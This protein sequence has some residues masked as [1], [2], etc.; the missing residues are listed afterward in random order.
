MTLL[1]K[2]WRTLSLHSRGKFTSKKIISR[3]T[4]F[5]LLIAVNYFQSVAPSIRVNW[6]FNYIHLDQYSTMQTMDGSTRLLTAECISMVYRFL[7]Y[8]MLTIENI[9]VYKV[10]NCF[11]CLIKKDFKREK[12]FTYMLSIHFYVK[13]DI[14]KNE[15]F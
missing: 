14:T 12:D 2:V 7:K 1:Y 11:L 15:K 3:F 5:C 8:T 10:I 6:P 13:R 9:E 4:L